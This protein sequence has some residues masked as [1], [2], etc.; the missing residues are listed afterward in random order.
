M[1]KIALFSAVAVALQIGAALQHQGFDIGRQHV[2][3]GRKHRVGALAAVLDHDIAGIVDEVGVVAGAAV[4]G[5]RPDT[6]VEEIAAA[7]AV[8]RVGQGVAV[9]LQVGAALQHQV[10]H[11]GCQPVADHRIHGVGAVARTLDHRVAGVVD[12]IGVVAGAADQSVVAY[13]AD[14]RVVAGETAQR[15]SAGAVPVRTLA[16]VVAVC[17]RSR[18][19]GRGSGSRHWSAERVAVT[20]GQH[21]IR[22]LVGVLGTTSPALSTT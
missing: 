15:V 9:A 4:H 6:A 1:P 18:R 5:V 16:P 14:Q 7:I 12:E 10:F 3:H 8:D 13:A 2:V 11:L 22:S 19:A 20:E 17:R 21:R